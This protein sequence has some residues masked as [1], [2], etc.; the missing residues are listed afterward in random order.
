MHV[1][2]ASV[3]HINFHPDFCPPPPPFLIFSL[4]PSSKFS[5]FYLFVPQ[6]VIRFMFNRSN[7]KY[8]YTRWGLC[9]LSMDENCKQ[10][11]LFVSKLLLWLHN[12]IHQHCV[13]TT[14]GWSWNECEYSHMSLK[15]FLL[16]QGTCASTWLLF[17]RSFL[18]NFVVFFFSI[19]GQEYFK[20]TFPPLCLHL[21]RTL[22]Y[23]IS[24]DPPIIF[25]VLLIGI[26]HSFF[27]FFLQL[28]WRKL[29]E[30]SRTFRQ[31]VTSLSGP[32]SICQ[33]RCRDGNMHMVLLRQQKEP[34]RGMLPVDRLWHGS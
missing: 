3:H 9:L 30:E 17:T 29:T 28:I 14:L 6:P 32:C 25:F 21:F 4:L 16:L 15:S 20:I 13:C 12:S 19:K 26:I 8:S 33:G 22:L 5:L 31:A 7:N 2:L 10:V 27:F 18:I 11:Q 34:G 1:K 24:C 23:D